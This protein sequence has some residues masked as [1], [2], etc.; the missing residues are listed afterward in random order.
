MHSLLYRDHDIQMTLN[1]YEMVTPEVS[2][3]LYEVV[4]RVLRTVS[5]DV[6]EGKLTLQ[7]S[8]DKLSVNFIRHKKREAYRID[9]KLFLTI[10]SIREY[11]DPPGEL[12][13]SSAQHLHPH[14]EIEVSGKKNVNTASLDATILFSVPCQLKRCMLAMLANFCAVKTKDKFLSIFF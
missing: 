5:Y 12:S 2:P 8:T 3:Q 4:Q 13:L 9:E 10:T 7:P 14:T 1:F 6:D 11:Q